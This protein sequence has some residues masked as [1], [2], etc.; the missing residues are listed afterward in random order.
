MR[1]CICASQ[2]PFATG[3]AEL[4]VDSLR[5]QFVARGFEVD[6]VALPFAWEPHRQVLRSAFA[7]RLLKLMEEP[8]RPIDLVIAT[9]FPSYLIQHPMKVVWMVHQFRQ[10]Y[11]LLGTP[12]S[13][14]GDSTEDRDIVRMV[15]GMDARALGEC[16]RRYAIARNPADRLQRFN[17]LSA[18]VL[19][20]PPPLD[21]R[22][23]RGALGDY[24]FTVSR[25]DAMK[26][27]D[28]LV[29][30]LAHTRTPVRVKIAGR[31]PE[32]EALER[33]VAELGVQARVDL[34][35][36]V[37][38]ERLVDLYAGSLA[39]YYAPF[40]EDYG[41]VTVEAFRSGKPV[42]T[43]SDAGGVLE[44]VEDGQTGLVAEPDAPKRIAAHLDHLFTD[45][46]LAQQL[47]EA[48]RQRA[49]PIGWDHVIQALTGV[50]APVEGA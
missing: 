27:V 26:R 7:W 21:G 42:V 6:V 19:Y 49:E 25:L 29:R 36:W 41:Y 20:P 12:Y 45:R 24:V 18:D 5:Q 13:D 30:A 28:L 16:H 33:L 8:G 22:Y 37:D 34:L 44:F 9:K 11:E 32:R 50:R 31:G 14:Y 43:T 48:G 10:V 40:D 23:R 4:L 47:G 38:D 39:V 1:I 2:V 15:R 17:G 3:G 46:A 35:G